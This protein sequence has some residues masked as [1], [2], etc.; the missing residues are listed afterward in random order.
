MK[1]KKVTVLCIAFLSG[2]VGLLLFIVMWAL[3]LPLASKYG[4]GLSLAIC[5]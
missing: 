4:N 3:F 2:I 5:C 1:I